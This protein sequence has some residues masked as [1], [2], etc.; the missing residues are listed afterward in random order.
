MSG[1]RRQGTTTARGFTR[2]DVLN[3]VLVGVAALGGV[4]CGP[5]AAA[6]TK[7]EGAGG[8]PP[9]PLP[10]GLDKGDVRTIAH[11]LRDG[12]TW[13]IP[14][15]TGDLLDVVVIGGGISGL[16]AAWKLCKLGHDAILV[17]EKDTPVGGFA[18]SDGA[19]PLLYSQAAAYTVLPYNE[20]LIALY[21]DLGIVTGTDAKGV[22]KLAEGYELATPVNNVHIGG[23]WYA[24]AWETGLDQLPFDA[25][26]KADLAAFRD[27]MKAYY[28]YVG[29]DGKIGFDTPSDASTTDAD[30]RALDDLTLAE[31]VAKKGWDS[32]VSE[33]WDPYCRSALGTTHDQV[34][35][36][37]AVNFLGSEFHPTISRPGGNA[38]LGR[39]LAAKVGET[40]VKT[41]AFVIRAVNAGDEVHVTYLVD[42]VTTTVRA[43][44]AI[45][46]GP[47]FV[48]RHVL[49]D[50]VAEGRDEAGSFRYSP[51]VVANV[52]VTK[53]PASLG[54]DNWF[55]DDGYFMT[56][57]IVADWAG[58]KDPSSLPLDRANVLSVYCP[59]VESGWRK[60]LETLSFA[61]L[62]ARVLESLEKAFPSIRG[63]ITQLD[64]Y[65]WGHAMLVSSKGFVFGAPRVGAQKPSGRISYACHDVDGVPAFEN[66][67]AS[68]IR[69]ATEAAAVVAG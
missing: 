15:A 11:K 31:W 19:D 62:E 40:R 27:A 35:A 8:A 30:V 21:T 17:L 66:A 2:R 45:Y 43:K 39:A 52:H 53:T 68:G 67:V 48:A 64:L 54:Y 26:V 16:T 38:H 37:A 4:A 25:K 28:D 63:T 9:S 58:Q 6:E 44:A 29:K 61:D 22:A 13:P 14:A 18:R 60:E 50:L 49:P 41:N 59:L 7:A 65:R 1:D 24:D 10:P 34:S 69:A 46:A 12:A 47:R 56:D 42:G 3:G 51:Y 55:H 20:N 32:K 23:T 57:V 33:F 36:W 5:G